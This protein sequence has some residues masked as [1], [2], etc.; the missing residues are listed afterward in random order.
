MTLLALALGTY[1]LKAAGPLALGGDRR[2]PP[3]IERLAAALPAALLAA[4]VATS[5]LVTGGTWTVDARLVGLGAATLAL[6]RR[7]PFVVVVLVA[8]G[9][10]ALA[11][12]VS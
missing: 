9:A 10:T 1:G 12:A 6:W 2:L 3:L 5:T 11:R 7:L 4:L 8:A